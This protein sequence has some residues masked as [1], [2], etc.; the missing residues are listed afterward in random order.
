MGYANRT[1]G[2]DRFK[3]LTAVVAI[4]GLFAYALVSGMGVDIANTVSDGF[5]IINV[6]PAKPDS[7]EPLKPS[8][9]PAKADEGA[10]APK[11][12][13]AEATQ[14]VAPEPEIKL[15]AKPP[16]VSAPKAGDGNA[17]SAGA[18]D[19]PGPGFGSGGEGSGTGSGRGGDGSGSGGIVSGPRHISGSITRQ[20]IPRA[21]WNEKGHG[22]VVAHFTV[23]ANGR[24]TR[25]RIKT[26]SGYPALDRTTCRLIEER[27]RFEPAKDARGRAVTHPYGWLQEWWLGK[28]R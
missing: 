18:S 5:K 16:L 14:I 24:V 12:R 4:H 7:Q 15:K 27:F 3:A 28:P 17:N 2:A 13:K 10:A 11:N 6:T 8:E 23:E 19:R 26:S 25:C 22:K 20:D 21:V 9:K 1:N